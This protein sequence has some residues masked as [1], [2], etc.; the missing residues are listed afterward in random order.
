MAVL[1]I[2]SSDGVAPGTAFTIETARPR[3][4]RRRPSRPR[5]RRWTSSPRPSGC[6]TRPRRRSTKA[7]PPNASNRP[8]RRKRRKRPK[9][10]RPTSPRKS[11]RKTPSPDGRRKTAI[12]PQAHIRGRLHRRRAWDRLAQGHAAFKRFLREPRLLLDGQ[13]A[14]VGH[15]RRPAEGHR[16][17]PQEGQK[18]TWP[19]KVSRPRSLWLRPSQGPRPA[20]FALAPAMPLAT[21]SRGDLRL[22]PQREGHQQGRQKKDPQDNHEADRQ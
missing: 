4:R 21:L 22:D 6:R 18:H 15:H 19:L 9:K 13:A 20:S 16:P 5:P 14:D 7:T 11:P 2:G 17:Q 3:A 12:R 10:S 8:P 1:D